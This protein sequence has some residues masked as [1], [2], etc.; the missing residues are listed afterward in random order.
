[1][2]INTLVM[3]Y[4]LGQP[5]GDVPNY[6]ANYLQAREASEKRQTSMLI[7]V[8]SADCLRCEAAW[9]A[10]A[11]DAIA[12]NAYVSTQVAIENFDG[13]VI[14]DMYE[15]GNTPAWIVL[16]ADGHIKEKWTGG[17]K[18]A[19]GNPTVYVEPAAGSKTKVVD[20][21]KKE[22]QKSAAP[23]E[24][25]AENKTPSAPSV[26][27]PGTKVASPAVTPP[28]EI[29]D[30]FVLQAGYFGSEANAQKCITDMRAKGCGAY[31]IKTNIKDGVTYYRVISTSFA[32]EV[33]ANTKM[34][35]ATK[36]GAKVTVKK[37]SE[38]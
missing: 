34:S 30:G 22:V 28:T 23:V 20:T 25:A 21:P 37:V 9:N 13:K 6:F 33:E 15:A 35:E 18:D 38:I 7:F 31:V 10:Y 27:K 24:V 4:L 5:L 32:S 11:K 29:K 1:M 2:W 14:A 26:S 19:A 16:D 12:V 36:A 3:L 8:S 17:W